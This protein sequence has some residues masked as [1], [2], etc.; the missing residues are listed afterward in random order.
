MAMA[1]E[2]LSMR[3]VREVLHLKHALGM[4]YRKIGEA[5]GASKTQAA[6]YVRRAALAG[7]TWPVP[8]GMDDAE[9]ERRLFPVA[10]AGADARAAIDWPAIQRELKRRSVTLALLWQE[11]LA[12]HQNG[13]SYTRFCELYAEWRK[14]VSPTM[15]QTHV[16]GEKLFVDWA[17]DTIAVVDPATGEERRAHVFVAAL[18]ASNFTYAQA[19]WSETLPDW[20]GAHAHAFAA[21]GGV[22]R[23]L[24]PDNLKAG[25]TKPSRY[26]PGI[27]RTYQDLAD[28]YGCVV[29]PTRIRH[30]RDKAK[31]EVAV[32]IVERFVLAKLRNQTF[33]SL[34]QL[35]VA[36]RECVAAINAKIMRHIGK[37]RAEL[38]ETIDRPALKALPDAPYAYAEWHRARVAPDY[39]IEVAGHFY[40]VPSRLIREIVEVRS[41][42]DTIEIFHRGK[43]IAS[44]ARSL[45]RH[46]HTTTPE[47]M[48]SAHRRFAQWTPARMMNEAAQIGPATTALFEAIMKAKPHPEQG[49]R[50]CLGIINL[51]KSYGPARVEAAC[52][53]GND[54]GATTYGSIA[55][56]L[57]NGLDKAF[58][59]HAREAANDAAFHHDNIR[60]RDY[61]H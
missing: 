32:Q 39:H 16:A 25:I 43:R 38:L 6:D 14:R 37:S 8:E 26:E 21:I 12:E 22:P 30:P 27:N 51:V 2:R 15:R 60:G 4:S 11:Y 5:T 40:S 36:I 31:V 54:I 47:H 61:Y 48:P 33:F 56:I 7:I 50:S 13:Y 9:L 1:A 55:S 42:A 18:G 58:A 23:A 3:K 28:H 19:C 46:R 49:F 41:T 35:N 57:K 53:R 59:E 45:S 24:V 29:L 10:D 34:A 20:I 44:H 52:Q 17:G